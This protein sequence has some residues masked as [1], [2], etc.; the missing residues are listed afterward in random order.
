MDDKSIAICCQVKARE[1]HFQV[2]LP[3]Y[4]FIDSLRNE[5]KQISLSDVMMYPNYFSEKA[6]KHGLDFSDNTNMLKQ[7]RVSLTAELKRLILRK[8]FEDSD[9]HL[10]H[11]TLP[12]T[13]S[14]SELMEG[15]NRY[16]EKIKP[17][18]MFRVPAFFDW[19]HEDISDEDLEDEE[20]VQS[21]M[22]LLYKEDNITMDD[23]KDALHPSVRDF[24]WANNYKFPTRRN[25]LLKR[26][27]RARLNIAPNTR[28]VF[29]NKYLLSRF[30]IPAFHAYVKNNQVIVENKT[31]QWTRLEAVRCFYFV[32]GDEEGGVPGA[33]EQPEVYNF[34]E[35]AL[36]SGYYKVFADI[37]EPV[38][39]TRDIVMQIRQGEWMSSDTA[40]YD[41]LS[42]AIT[43]LANMTNIKLSVAYTSASKK[44]Y[45]VLPAD[46]GDVTDAV[47]HVEPELA[48]RIG[49][50]AVD[51]ITYRSRAIEAATEDLDLESKA[52]TLVYN[53]RVVLIT[54]DQTVSHSTLNANQHVMALLYPMVDGTMRSTDWKGK[55]SVVLPN[56]ALGSD[57]IA[58]KCNLWTFNVK[59]EKIP[60][61]WNTSAT[62]TGI[63]RSKKSIK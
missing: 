57:R 39:R 15:L 28:I 27:L 48:L 60:L 36:Q 22:T 38:V 18:A 16:F 33:E 35:G 61:R 11:Y 46:G 52:R 40:I 1:S 4:F 53:T 50:G 21:L 12:L 8:G 30:G 37:V 13:V 17:T 58:F 51:K 23:I 63:V 3:N 6:A 26:S 62:V 47:L 42:T 55:T 44:F 29:S 49:Y 10:I 9:K 7:S 45:F 56:Y 43:M 24:K 59:G 5:S 2:D 34:I 14:A 19:G 25:A 31:D 54:L 32:Q 41:M 20:F